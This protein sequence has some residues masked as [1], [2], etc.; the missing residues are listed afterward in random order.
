MH[1]ANGHAIVSRSAYGAK[2]AGAT[3][4]PTGRCRPRRHAWALRILGGTVQM[5]AGITRLLAI[6]VLKAAAAAEKAVEAY[7]HPSPY[8]NP[9][10]A[11]EVSRLVQ[12]LDQGSLDLRSTQAPAASSIPAG[13]SSAGVDHSPRR[14]PA[15][16]GPAAS[17][18]FAY[19]GS[20]PPA[21]HG[22]ASKMLRKSSNSSTV[23]S[24][25]DG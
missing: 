2:R 6:A 4:V 10:H 14:P 17:S 25:P 16:I 12:V 8:Q 1:A 7:R 22:F 23:E 13:K 15:M 3:G 11:S 18:A 24:V 9:V 19:M 21:R 20:L 5:A